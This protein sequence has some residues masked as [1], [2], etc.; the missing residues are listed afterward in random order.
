VVRAWKRVRALPAG[1]DSEEEAWMTGAGR[2][3]AAQMGIALGGF[4]QKSGKTDDFG[5]EAS[6]I[7]YMF[8]RFRRREDYMIARKW[9]EDWRVRHPPKQ[10]S[11]TVY[12][13]E[14]DDPEPESKKQKIDFSSKLNHKE[15]STSK[16]KASDVAD[17]DEMD[18]DDRSTNIPQFNPT[19]MPAREEEH[20]SDDDDDD[21]ED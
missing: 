3:Q 21:D 20:W 17:D 19:P 13:S 1:Y 6:E 14:S 8:G 16:R 18:I 15:Q 2:P 9:Y 7:A 10:E 5:A 12:Y 4:G 11:V